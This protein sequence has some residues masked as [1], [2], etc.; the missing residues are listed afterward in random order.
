MLSGTKLTDRQTDTQAAF[1]A[2]V[3][4]IHEVATAQVVATIQTNESAKAGCDI[5]RQMFEKALQS[6]LKDFSPGRT[7]GI[8]SEKVNIFQLY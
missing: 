4:P 1:W 7:R 2:R 8:I 5:G 6:R 3:C